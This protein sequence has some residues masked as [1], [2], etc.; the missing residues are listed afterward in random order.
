M[1]RVV[2]QLELIVGQIE[3]CSIHLQSEAR[4]V[5]K[6]LCMCVPVDSANIDIIIKNFKLI[7]A[8]ILVFYS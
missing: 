2:L 4:L 5:A 7:V 3:C 8:L 6:S 1:M